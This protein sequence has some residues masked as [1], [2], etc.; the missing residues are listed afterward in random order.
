M[1]ALQQHPRGDVATNRTEV[2]TEV[3]QTP[4]NGTAPKH[5]ETDTNI[6]KLYQFRPRMRALF[7]LEKLLYFNDKIIAKNIIYDC[8]CYY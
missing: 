4:Q 7:G 6:N 3:S 8:V 1:K 5:Q 2:R